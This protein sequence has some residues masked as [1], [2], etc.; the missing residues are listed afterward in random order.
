MITWKKRGVYSCDVPIHRIRKAAIE[1]LA[2]S[3]RRTRDPVMILDEVISL[4]LIDYDRKHF[5]S[6]SHY[7]LSL[8]TKEHLRRLAK[9]AKTTQQEYIESLIL[10]KAKQNPITTTTKE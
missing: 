10:E 3:Q 7:R 4:G 5:M 1:R 2:G 9:E 8:S 6:R